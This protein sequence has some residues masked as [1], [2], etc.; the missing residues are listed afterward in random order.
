[1]SQARIFVPLQ[2]VLLVA[3]IHLHTLSAVP[4]KRYSGPSHCY[5]YFK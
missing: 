4:T 2:L 3:I 5:L 1:M